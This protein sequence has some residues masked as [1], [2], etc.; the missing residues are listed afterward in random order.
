MASHSKDSMFWTTKFSQLTI[1]NA[2]K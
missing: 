2:P 1:L